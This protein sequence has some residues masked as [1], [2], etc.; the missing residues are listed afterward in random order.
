MREGM[1]HFGAP[2]LLASSPHLREIEDLGPLA[3][4]FRLRNSCNRSGEF[5]V[6]KLIESI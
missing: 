5:S 3:S 2:L 4:N 6:G 1:C